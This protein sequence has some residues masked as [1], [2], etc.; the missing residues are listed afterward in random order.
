MKRTDLIALTE[1]LAAGT[2]TGSESRRL[3]DIL[4]QIAESQPVCW[5]WPASDGVVY[6]T[7]VPQEH[8]RHEGKYTTPLYTLPLE[9]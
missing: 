6:D 4:R 2:I 3:A 5:G 7:I 1:L 9:D 8:Q